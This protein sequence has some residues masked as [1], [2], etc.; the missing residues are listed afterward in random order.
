MNKFSVSLTCWEKVGF[1][2]FLSKTMLFKILS[3]KDQR[4]KTLN[5]VCA[6]LENVTLYLWIKIGVSCELGSCENRRLH[7]FRCCEITMD[8]ARA[9]SQNKFS[10]YKLSLHNKTYIIQEKW[11]K[12]DFLLLS[13]FTFEQSWKKTDTFVELWIHRY[14]MLLLRNPPFTLPLLRY[15]G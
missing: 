15:S 14:V 9:A 2:R 8:F 13:S 4:I 7:I 3:P 12:I 6:N 5:W 11:Q 1:N 10:I